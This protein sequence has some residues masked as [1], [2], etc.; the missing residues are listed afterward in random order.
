MCYSYFF[1]FKTI[2]KYFPPP[3][4][5]TADVKNVFE[6]RLCKISQCFKNVYDFDAGLF[7]TLLLIIFEC[8]YCIQLC[9]YCLNAVERLLRKKRKPPTKNVGLNHAF[10]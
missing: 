5:L 8:F 2:K 9:A 7:F 4:A 6:C 10:L 3:R 1:P